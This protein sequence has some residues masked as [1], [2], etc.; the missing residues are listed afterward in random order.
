MEKRPP[1]CKRIAYCNAVRVPSRTLVIV[2]IRIDGIRGIETVGQRDIL[3]KGNTLGITGLKG[4]YCFP[5]AS[6][7]TF[8]KFP[9][10]IQPGTV[11]CLCPEQ[12]GASE[13]ANQQAQHD[14]FSGLNH[15]LIVKVFVFFLKFLW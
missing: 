1:V 9:V 2:H 4:S 13:S 14:K 7:V 6:K 11:F 8:E 12:A 15:C 3:P 10:I 5:D